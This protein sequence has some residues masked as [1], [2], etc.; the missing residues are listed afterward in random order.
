[1]D[2]RKKLETSEERIERLENTVRVLI[3]FT[4]MIERETNCSAHLEIDFDDTG[5]PTLA[6]G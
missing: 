3:G 4:R 6:K 5:V 1:M 2:K